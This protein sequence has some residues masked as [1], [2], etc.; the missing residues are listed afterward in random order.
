MEFYIEFNESK[1]FQGLYSGGSPLEVDYCFGLAIHP[2]SKPIDLHFYIDMPEQNAHYQ[3][4][5]NRTVDVEI[6]GNPSS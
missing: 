5:I 2:C 1:Y 4:T 3:H 6:P